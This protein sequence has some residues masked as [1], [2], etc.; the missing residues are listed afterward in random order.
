MPEATVGSGMIDG[1][2]GFVIVVYVVTWITV[3]GLVARAVMLSRA[4]SSS[5][6]P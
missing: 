2:W 4:V 6:N 3:A 1:G 5:E